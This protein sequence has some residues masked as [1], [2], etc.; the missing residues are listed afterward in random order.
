MS[1][2]SSRTIHL[3]ILLFYT[4]LIFH[5][6][7][8][9]KRLNPSNINWITSTWDED[10]W[11]AY[12]GWEQFRQSPWSFPPAEN[13]RVGRELSGS[14]IHSGGIPLFEIPLKV[15]N[16]ILPDSF[17][18]FGIWIF[19]CFIGQA[20]S[21]WKIA[22]LTSKSYVLRHMASVGL[23]FS[24]I[25]LSKINQHHGLVAQFLIVFAIYLVF[26]KDKRRR[27]IYWTILLACSA[28]VHAYIAAMVALM[29]TSSI[30]DS[31]IKKRL[32]IG[33]FTKG[34]VGCLIGFFLSLWASGYFLLG[35]TG[36]DTGWP[37]WLWKMDLLQPFNFAGWSHS[38]SWLRQDLIGNTEGFAY[39][40]VW[41]I[42][43]I[44]V[45]IVLNPRLFLQILAKVRNN[46]TFS[47]LLVVL[48]LF[49]LTNKIT[50]GRNE[51]EYRIPNFFEDYYGIFRASGRFFW[52]IYYLIIL[53]ALHV[54]AKIDRERYARI[55]LGLLLCFHI[56]DTEKYWGGISSINDV[57]EIDNRFI[58]LKS[59]RWNELL[60]NR[61]SIIS[62]PITSDLPRTRRCPNWEKINF[63]AMQN[64]IATNCVYL[65]RFD[66]SKILESKSII[67]Q[68]L[69][70]GAIEPDLLY[71]LTQQEIERFERVL[72]KNGVTFE[73]IDGIWVVYKD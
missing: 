69:K 14:I 56:V 57:E 11:I 45:S 67:E 36:L 66:V 25:F 55:I 4:S 23:L 20:I 22:G 52:P 16:D 2:I 60:S 49:A 58:G 30:S 17:Q 51:F 63:L 35:G 19:F 5:F 43:L 28:L 12:V 46:P 47:L 13:P 53:L 33:E 34:L 70:M 73:S 37:N 10:Y 41:P 64:E 54:I 29:F 68:S 44:F 42:I 8:G 71:I 62:I 6:V 48:L 9:F 24:P 32:G 61:N 15:I 39:L 26:R 21:G 50:V 40:G 72:L 27:F 7:V 18:Y 3:G 59:E 1:S 65:A 38:L 31:L